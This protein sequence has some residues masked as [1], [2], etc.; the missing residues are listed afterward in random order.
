MNTKIDNDAN[1]ENKLAEAYCE[2]ALRTLHELWSCHQDIP[3]SNQFYQNEK[4]YY[5]DTTFF[6]NTLPVPLDERDRILVN[7]LNSINLAGKV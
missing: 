4:I 7:Y 6:G 2:I 3:Q 1:C 5:P